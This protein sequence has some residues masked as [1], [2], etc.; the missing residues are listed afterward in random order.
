MSTIFGLQGL[1]FKSDITNIVILESF[2]LNKRTR[3]EL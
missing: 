3:P 2:G 1:S